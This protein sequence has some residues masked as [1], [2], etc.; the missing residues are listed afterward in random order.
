LTEK[1]KFYNGKKKASSINGED[2]TGSLYVEENENR[3][4][5]VTLNK[6]QVQVDQGRQHKPDTPNLIEDKVDMENVIHLH[7]GILLCY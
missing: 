6:V 1:Q 7:N 2:L 3:P 4:I 5:F